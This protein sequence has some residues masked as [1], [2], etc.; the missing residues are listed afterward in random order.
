MLSVVIAEAVVVS[1]VDAELTL[2]SVEVLLLTVEVLVEFAVVDSEVTE[3]ASDVLTEVELLIGL[4]VVTVD[5]D[6][7]DELLVDSTVVEA[8]VL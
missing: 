1:V 7:K 2:F 4:L 3:E 5:D 8:E 6:V